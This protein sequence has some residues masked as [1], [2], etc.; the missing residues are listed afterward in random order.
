MIRRTARV[1]VYGATRPLPASER[2]RFSQPIVGEGGYVGQ[3]LAMLIARWPIGGF[4]VIDIDRLRSL[5]GD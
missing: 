4:L 3:K 2:G 5:H 1:A